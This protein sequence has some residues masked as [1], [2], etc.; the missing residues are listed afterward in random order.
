MARHHVI[1]ECDWFVLGRKR[2]IKQLAFYDVVNH[3]HLLHV[4]RFPKSYQRYAAYFDRQ[5]AHS[6]HIPWNKNGFFHL[7]GVT[8]A[9]RTIQYLYHDRDVVFWAKGQEKVNILSSHGIEVHNLEDLGC[10]R[11]EELSSIPKTTLNKARVF[12]AWFP[13]GEEDDISASLDEHHYVY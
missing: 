3:M 8:A 6:H 5:S 2:L 12:A 11:F 9:I 13:F 7:S 1:L 4:F 10:P